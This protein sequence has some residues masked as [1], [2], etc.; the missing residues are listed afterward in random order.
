MAGKGS[1][2]PHMAGRSHR[3]LAPIGGTFTTPL[4]KRTFTCVAHV[5][6]VRKDGYTVVVP[7]WRIPCVQ[8]HAP[9]DHMR[10]R[11]KLVTCRACLDGY[12]PPTARVVALGERRRKWLE[13]CA[14]E[15]DVQIPPAR[16]RK[17][18]PWQP[19]HQS[20]AVIAPTSGVFTD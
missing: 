17:P 10:Y 13:Q 6:H 8:C 14:V 11:P 1:Y 9:W 20:A 2:N 4:S 3:K 12:S 19:E 7:V 5:D 16:P 15:Q 18:P